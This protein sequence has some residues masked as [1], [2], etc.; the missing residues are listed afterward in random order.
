MHISFY[1]QKMYVYAS[2]YFMYKCTLLFIMKSIIHI[3][4]K[5]KIQRKII[6]LGKNGKITHALLIN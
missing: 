6:I 1:M 5:M 2:I 3:K 4:E